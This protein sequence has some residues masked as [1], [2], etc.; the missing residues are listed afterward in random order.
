MNF[1]TFTFRRLFEMYQK[2]KKIES[3]SN[4]SRFNFLSF[5]AGFSAQKHF[6][7]VPVNQGRESNRPVRPS[8]HGKKLVFV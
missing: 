7:M 5:V 2:D 4:K 8:F 1:P 3:P 6:K